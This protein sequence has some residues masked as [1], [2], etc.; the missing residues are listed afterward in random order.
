[1]RRIKTSYNTDKAGHSETDTLI[2][3]QILRTCR[4]RPIA[5]LSSADKRSSPIGKAGQG[6]RRRD[7]RYHRFDGEQ[8]EQNEQSSPLCR[9][10]RI[11]EQ[12]EQ[13]PYKRACLFA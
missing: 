5:I 9:N 4:I 2:D 11:G 12:N 13:G 7:G 8:N 6:L 3:T 10:V 1:M